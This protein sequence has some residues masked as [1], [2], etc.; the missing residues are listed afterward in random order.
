MIPLLGT[1]FLI[2]GVLAWRFPNH[3][4]V[5]GGVLFVLLLASWAWFALTPAPELVDAPVASPA[6]LEL[7]AVTLEPWHGEHR[8]RGIAHNR[9]DIVVVTG[10][11]ARIVLRDCVEGDCTSLGV[12]RQPF[13]LRIAPSSSVEFERR[14]RLLPGT[15]LAIAGDLEFDF[16]VE[17]VHGRRDLRRERAQQTREN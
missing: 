3:R 8:L 7:E 11:T 16:H 12:H 10:F 5:L 6:E 2:I 15:A 14:V 9:S 13:N 1:I 4:A 17:E